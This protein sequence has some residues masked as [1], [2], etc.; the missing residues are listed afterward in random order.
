MG[1]QRETENICYILIGKPMPWRPRH[2]GM[3]DVREIVR[4]NVN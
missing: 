1:K 4:K 2:S 3:G